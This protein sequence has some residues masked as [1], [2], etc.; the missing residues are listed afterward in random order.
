LDTSD[1][2]QIEAGDEARIAT[3]IANGV[4]RIN[5]NKREIGEELWGIFALKDGG[6]RLLTE[7]SLQWPIACSQR[8][9]FD[10]E[11]DWVPRVLW[12]QLDTPGLR[13]VATYAPD[14]QHFGISVYEQP[15]RNGDNRA[16]NGGNT[17]TTD[18]FRNANPPRQIFH[19]SVGRTLATFLDFG[20]TLFN[21]A[22]LRA[23]RLKVGGEV[24]ITTVVPMQPSLL[25]MQIR[26]TYTYTRDEQMTN[27]I[28]GFAA[29]RRYV[30]TEEGD[31]A[32]ITTLWNDAHDV[33]LR[34][35]IVMGTESHGCELVHYEWHGP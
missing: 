9:R 14:L 12:V 27:S 25:P 3:R 23:L 20:S 35:E 5:H 1:D 15:L 6:Y 32:P 10:L 2:F 21:F 18:G 26:Q 7:V 13:R 4:Y 30:I 22:H 33:C 31:R 16:R 19:D 8:V 34:Q 24:S 28:T 29:A 17:L 11:A